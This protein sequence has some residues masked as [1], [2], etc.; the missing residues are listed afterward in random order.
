MSLLPKSLHNHHAHWGHITDIRNYIKDEPTPKRY[1][2]LNYGTFW[3]NQLALYVNPGNK[4][5]MMFKSYETLYVYMDNCQRYDIK[6]SHWYPVFTDSIPNRISQI[7]NKVFC[8]SAYIEYS[9][10]GNANVDLR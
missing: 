1:K 4:I 8:K 9:K 10:Y 3:K 2:I 7:A 6:N 5:L